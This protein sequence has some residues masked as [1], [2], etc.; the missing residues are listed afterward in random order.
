[1]RVRG[2]H[3]ASFLNLEKTPRGTKVRLN[4]RTELLFLSS[5]QEKDG[6]SI[7]Q[8]IDYLLPYAFGEG[9]WPHK[10][11]AALEGF[12]LRD[13]LVAAPVEFGW[14]PQAFKFLQKSAV[15]RLLYPNGFGE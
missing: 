12:R 7:K 10:Q 8:A 4:L 6:Q 2:L 15:E 3:F 13:A 11:L 14:R 9:T 1:M 5:W